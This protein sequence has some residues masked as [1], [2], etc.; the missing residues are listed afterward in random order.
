MAYV[1]LDPVVLI[2]AQGL[3]E[4]DHRTRVIEADIFDPKSLLARRDVEE[5]FDWRRPVA[6]VHTMTLGHCP[7]DLEPTE[8]MTT[9]MEC[10]PAGSYSVV[11]HCVAPDGWQEYVELL[12]QP[13]FVE[14]FGNRWFRPLADLERLFTGQHLVRPR[15]VPAAEWLEDTAP[16]PQFSHEFVVAGIGCIDAASAERLS[17]QIDLEPLGSL[18]PRPPRR[19]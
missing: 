8:L 14:A 17:T 9:Y 6:L 11:S 12:Q 10:L 13:L 5:F 16:R 19:R 1:D 2:H 15:L 18:R 3:L 7:D 4:A